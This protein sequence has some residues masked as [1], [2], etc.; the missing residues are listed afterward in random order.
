[1]RSCVG[2]S[3][4]SWTSGRVTWFWIRVVNLGKRW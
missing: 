3:P 2:T 4:R 1:M